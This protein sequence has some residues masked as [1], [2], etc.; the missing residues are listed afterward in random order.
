MAVSAA[1]AMV[2]QVLD[3]KQFIPELGERQPAWLEGMAPQEPG[4][5]SW[6]PQG[7]S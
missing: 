2:A 7:S 6:V 1:T 3:E 4:E 5:R